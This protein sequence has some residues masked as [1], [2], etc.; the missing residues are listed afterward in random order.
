MRTNGSVAIPEDMQETKDAH[1]GRKFLEKLSLLC[2]LGEPITNTALSYCLHQV[3]AM[4]GVP[5]QTINAIHATAFLLVEI[6]ELA[7]NETVRDTFDSQITEFTS[8]MKLLVDDVNTKIDNHLQGALDQIDKAALKVATKIGAGARPNQNVTTTYA[9]ALINPPPNI[10]PKLAAKEGIRARQFLLTGIKESAFGQYDTQ[11][12]N[13]AEGR[14]HTH[15]SR[16]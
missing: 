1:D 10:N 16:L 6:E 14:K 2:P 4:P 7:I 8:D 11:R 5:K 12:L 13:Y 15:Q 3:S 9:S